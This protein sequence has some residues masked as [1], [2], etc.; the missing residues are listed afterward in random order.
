[1]SSTVPRLEDQDN[2]LAILTDR[3][4][5]WM[6]CE[7]ANMYLDLAAR[8]ICLWEFYRCRGTNANPRKHAPPKRSQLPGKCQEIPSHDPEME[9]AESVDVKQ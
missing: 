2:I 9:S 3:L 8:D 5:C 7:K 1:M 4:G 6:R